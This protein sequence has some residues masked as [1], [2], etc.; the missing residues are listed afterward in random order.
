MTGLE[1]AVALVVLA[2]AGYLYTQVFA[3]GRNKKGAD[4]AATSA[5]VAE[6]QAAQHK[7]TAEAVAAAVKDISVTHAKELAVHE[8]MEHNAANFS[9][10]A[11]AVL[12]AD[13]APSEYTIVAIGL[14]D[15]VETSLG[16]QFTDAQ[17]KAFVDRVVPLIKHNAEVEAAL[18]KEKADAAA[19]AASRDAEHQ[20]ALAAETQGLALVA[21][22]S[23][24]AKE[25]AASTAKSSQ[26][27]DANKAWADREQ[28]L[29]GRLKAAAVLGVLLILVIG[30]ISIKLFGVAKTRDNTVAFVEYMKKI[31]LEGVKDATD[32]KTKMTAWY[33][34]DIKAQAAVAKVKEKLRL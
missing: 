8:E 2:G 11:R 16:V 5:D 14:L 22:N 3:P 27:A 15:S 6:Q 31:A 26:L 30:G 34:G 1:V 18:A 32:L 10:Q 29:L 9:A 7:I 24:Q 28:T 12:Q 25:L 23:N 33:D 13:P 17:R 4:R 20:R 19:V 21:T